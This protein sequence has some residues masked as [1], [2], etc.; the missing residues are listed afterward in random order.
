[1]I[2]FRKCYNFKLIK[3]FQYTG[4]VESKTLSIRAADR[5]VESESVAYHSYQY[6]KTS[7]GKYYWNVDIPSYNIMVGRDL[8]S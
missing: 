3:C 2:L 4:K 7:A 8:K 6:Y 5:L 1:M